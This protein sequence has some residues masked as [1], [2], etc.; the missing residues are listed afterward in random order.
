MV[1]NVVVQVDVHL[2]QYV[3]W[4]AEANRSL[5]QSDSCT[6][7]GN[8][9]AR[10]SEA[11]ARGSHSTHPCSSTGNMWSLGDSAFKKQLAEGDSFKVRVH[12]RKKQS[13]SNYEEVTAP[14]PAAEGAETSA[15]EVCFRY[16]GKGLWMV[17]LLC[18]SINADGV[19]VARQRVRMPGH[20]DLRV[21][22]GQQFQVRPWQHVQREGPPGKSHSRAPFAQ[23][24]A[25]VHAGQAFCRRRQKN[26]QHVRPGKRPS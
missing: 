26:V 22:S 12:M 19:L 25:T 9:G 18:Y 4:H 1:A 13:G 17:Q 3:R 21:P 24:K 11:R 20:R 6:M 23:Q 16:L 7:A 8:D 2:W 5:P 10:V 14:A 15:V